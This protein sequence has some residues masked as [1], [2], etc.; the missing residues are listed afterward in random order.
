MKQNDSGRNRPADK[1]RNN[2]PQLRDYTGQQPGTSTVSSSNSDEENQDLSETAKDG[3][4]ED[5][6][7]PR[8]DRNLD[9]SNA[10]DENEK[11]Y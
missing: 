1:G 8:A 9:E 10:D 7:D 11:I 5:R 4:N 3:F 6:P 2:D